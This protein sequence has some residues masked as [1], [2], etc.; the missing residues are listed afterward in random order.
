MRNFNFAEA[1]IFM[2]VRRAW[3]GKQIFLMSR[4]QNRAAKV[5]AYF[6]LISISSLYWRQKRQRSTNADIR[7]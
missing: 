7:Y 6:P 3:Y 4:R 5:R 1:L 2:Y